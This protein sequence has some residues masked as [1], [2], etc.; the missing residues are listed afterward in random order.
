MASKR[1]EDYAISVFEKLILKRKINILSDLRS[2]KRFSNK[3]LTV[4]KNEI[5]TSELKL[6]CSSE[7]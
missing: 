3:V 5:L 4:M 2:F 6:N 1:V 7:T